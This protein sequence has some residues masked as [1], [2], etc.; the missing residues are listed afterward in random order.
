MLIDFLV[1]K[2]FYSWDKLFLVIPHDYCDIL[3]NFICYCLITFAYIF[4]NETTLLRL[5][6]VNCRVFFWDTLQWRLNNLNT[7]FEVLIGDQQERERKYSMFTLMAA[8]PLVDLGSWDKSLRNWSAIS[9]L[10]LQH[11]HYFFTYSLMGRPPA[12][13]FLYNR[14][15]HLLGAEKIEEGIE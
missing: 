3:L 14:F 10:F 1:L 15:S 4:I 8:F 9:Y 7:S 13:I 12:M 2:Y 5:I 6:R 11:V